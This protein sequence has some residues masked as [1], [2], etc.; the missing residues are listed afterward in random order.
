MLK[1]LSPEQL[2]LRQ[3]AKS[4][5]VSHN[6]PYM[7][8]PDKDSLLAA[9]AEQGFMLLGQAVDSSQQ[10]LHHKPITQRLT[11]AAHSYVTFALNHPSH[12]RVMFMNWPPG[13]CPDLY[14]TSLATF[15]KLVAIMA[16]G[17][18]QGELICPPTP[19]QLAIQVWMQLHGASTLLMGD[20]IPGHAA[21]QKDPKDLI[22]Q[23]VDLLLQGLKK[24]E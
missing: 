17:Q 2:S 24:G 8:F 23:I 12:F 14:P 4:L 6:A 5:G 15:N 3:L 18:E 11:S 9:I 19:D 22:E 7:H 13:L 16:Q 20:K 21:G 1:T 10:D